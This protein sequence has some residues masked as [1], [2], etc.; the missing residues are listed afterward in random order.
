[1]VSGF[2]VLKTKGGTSTIWWLPT[3]HNA[4]YTFFATTSNLPQLITVI[5]ACI[6]VYGLFQG[7]QQYVIAG[8]L[9]LIILFLY[10]TL[11]FYRGFTVTT[12]VVDFAYHSAA[13]C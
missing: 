13:F 10:Y 7:L 11:R 8:N 9:R 2:P 3:V 4:D 1:M 5:T 12:V 6:I